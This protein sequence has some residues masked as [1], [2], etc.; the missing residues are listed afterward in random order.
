MSCCESIRLASSSAAFASS[1]RYSRLST[2]ACRFVAV[3][4]TDDENR[5]TRGDP[6]VG[7]R[8]G[9]RDAHQLERSAL[10]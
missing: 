8:L 6:L 2:S 5:L 9:M 3:L 1:V 4:S 10:D 7:G